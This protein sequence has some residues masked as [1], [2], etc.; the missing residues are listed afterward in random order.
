MQLP[1]HWSVEFGDKS[2]FSG[3]G[4]SYWLPNKLSVFFL[5]LRRVFLC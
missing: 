5:E 4:Q 3:C 1:L 2:V